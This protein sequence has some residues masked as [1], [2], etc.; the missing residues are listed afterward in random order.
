MPINVYKMAKYRLR[1]NETLGFDYRHILSGDKRW[2][3]FGGTFWSSKSKSR[4]MRSAN[5][6]SR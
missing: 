5:Q 2:K 4:E 1:D 3:K 6:A